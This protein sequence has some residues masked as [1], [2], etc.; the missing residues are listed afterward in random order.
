MSVKKNF[1]SIQ[2]RLTFRQP[3]EEMF[4]RLCGSSPRFFIETFAD[5]LSTIQIPGFLKVFSQREKLS[6]TRIPELSKSFFLRSEK[7]SVVQ[8]PYEMR[9][10][11]HKDTKTVSARV[12]LR[13]KVLA[14]SGFTLIELL[15]VI[16]IIGILTGL[17]GS[18]FVRSRVRARDAERRSNLKDIQTA[19]EMY[20]NDNGRYPCRTIA[21]STG[22]ARIQDF[23]WGNDSFTNEANGHAETVYMAALPG[24]PSAPGAQYHYEVNDT[25]TKYRLYAWLEN[26]EDIERVEGG[27]FNKMCSEV[28]NSADYFCN[29]GIS[30]T[31]TTMTENWTAAGD[32][33]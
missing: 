26:E 4:I 23:E 14:Y 11:P 21:Y 27:Y 24:D 6:L 18:N 19:L 2:G 28:N 3:L 20:M 16:A 9:F 22:N 12:P 13:A 31:N 15:V 17:V 7:G 25:F 29:Y 1:S 10:A 32:C 5:S 30:S 8:M 33:S